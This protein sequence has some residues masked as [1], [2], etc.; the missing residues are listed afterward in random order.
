MPFIDGVAWEVEGC[1]ADDLEG[2]VDSVWHPLTSDE[3]RTI[4]V[5]LEGC[6]PG[7]TRSP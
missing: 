1:E 5:L 6:A 3:I 2:L 7:E 4:E